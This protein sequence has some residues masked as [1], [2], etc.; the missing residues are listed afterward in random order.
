MYGVHY[1]PIGDAVKEPLKGDE[2]YVCPGITIRTLAAGGGSLPIRRPMKVKVLRRLTQGI[3]RGTM[4][5][6]LYGIYDGIP[7]DDI[8][9]PVFIMPT[10]ML[11]KELP[12]K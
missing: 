5:V 7:M 9:Y 10:D 11:V 1:D 6:K 3:D 12:C 8:H 4:L 2:G